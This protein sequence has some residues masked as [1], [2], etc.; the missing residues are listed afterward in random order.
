MAATLSR[1]VFIREENI[2]MAFEFFDKD[3]TGS[4]TVAN[5]IEIFGSEQHAKEVI[6]DVDID[7]DMELSFGEFKTMMTAKQPSRKATLHHTGSHP[8]DEKAAAE[9]AD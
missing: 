4:I 7:G 6:G 5:L 9:S 1:N 8:A 3:A 2:R